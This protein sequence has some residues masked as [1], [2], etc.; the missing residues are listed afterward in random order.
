MSPL[1]E[2]FEGYC[3]QCGEQYY[4]LL[5]RFGFGNN[6]WCPAEALKILGENEKKYKYRLRGICYA[7]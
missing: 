1:P 4:R 3:D 2:E 7:M 5:C 6:P